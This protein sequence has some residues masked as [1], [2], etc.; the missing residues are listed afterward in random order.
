[1]L[2][3]VCVSVCDSDFLTFNEQH[4][5]SLFFS[6]VASSLV[7]DLQVDC[8]LFLSFCGKSVNTVF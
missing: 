6:V 3:V 7:S 2:R 5:L 8:K 1:M 4:E